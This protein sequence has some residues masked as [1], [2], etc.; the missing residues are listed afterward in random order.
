MEKGGGLQEGNRVAMTQKK[1][2]VGYGV[3]EWVEEE[4]IE[5]YC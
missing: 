3:G 1:E 4:K 2:G 5:S